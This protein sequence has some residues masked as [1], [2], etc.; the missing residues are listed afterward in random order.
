MVAMVAAAAVTAADAAARAHLNTVNNSNRTVRVNDRSYNSETNNYC[1]WVVEQRRNNILPPGDKYLT[2]E[3]VDLYFSE[4][5]VNRNICYESARRVVSA[6]QRFASDIEYLGSDSFT[7]ES[8]LVKKAL[9]ARKRLH[10]ERI[11]SQI[12]DPHANL[13]TNVLSEAD[14]ANALR[15]A[16]TKQN[17]KDMMLCWSTCE[18]TYL[19][20]DSMRKLCLPHLRCDRTH[21]P[22]CMSDNN[23]GA[24]YGFADGHMMSFILDKYVHKTRDDKKRVVGAWR[25]KEYIRCSIGNL[26]MNLLVRMYADVEI[27][28]YGAPMGE[29]TPMWWDRKLIV[30]WHDEKASYEAFCA[31]LDEA[32]L[33]WAK[34]THLR[35]QGIY[36]GS[37]RGELESSKIGTMSKHK[38]EKIAVYETELFPPVLRVMSGFRQQSCYLVPR[39]R[40]FPCALLREHQFP[41]GAIEQDAVEAATLLLF[42]R[43][44]V[45][46]EQQS[47]PHGDTSEAAKNFLYETLP[48][49]AVTAVQDGIYWI[50][51]FPTHEASL[52]LLH[53]MPPWYPRWAATVRRTCCDMEGRHEMQQART[54]GD[55]SYAAFLALQRTILELQQSN[56]AMQRSIA[57]LPTQM[58]ARAARAQ[59]PPPPIQANA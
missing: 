53:A 45:W 55:G 16:A 59:P 40:V 28:F 23:Y 51:D 39:T 22:S 34:K 3:G 15:L 7:V 29:A 41:N 2:R 48:Y 18:Q 47:G 52:F 57:Q 12:E 56:L 21:A 38:T 11:M 43:I 32:G 14:C 49:L 25:H 54:M 17:W 33:S 58:N 4:H 8:N 1:V 42:P 50:V 9:E 6:L 46:R 10:R 26:A 44:R 19:R 35:K 27:N 36:A 30:E 37:T 31:L 20:N 13:P 5:V 24:G